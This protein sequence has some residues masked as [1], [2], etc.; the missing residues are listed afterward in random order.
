MPLNI[1]TKEYIMLDKYN[2]WTTEDFV[3]YIEKLENQINSKEQDQT[4]KI[5]WAGNL[6]QWTWF[7]KENKVIFNDLKVKS[8]GYDPQSIGKVNFEFFTTKLHPEDYERVMNNMRNHLKGKTGAYEVEYRIRHQDGHYLWYYDRGV[9]VKRENDGT[10]IVLEGIVFD[11]SESKEV[12][13]KLSFYAERD[14]LTQ[15]MNRRMFFQDINNSIKKYEN[16]QKEFSLIMVDLD[17]FKTINDTYGHLVGDET[18]VT[19]IKGIS[20]AKELDNNLY[21]YGGDEFFMLL[22]N[23]KLEDAIRFGKN[24]QNIIQNLQF[25]QNL[26]L[27]ASMGIVEYQDSESIDELIKRVDDLMYVAKQKGRNQFAF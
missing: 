25:P 11:I 27:T 15:V 4:V 7:Y 21:R 1:T 8:L 18:L 3:A 20:E 10:P 12:E 9:V 6:G 16:N 24:L 19:L 5:K 13:Q 14:I 17:H 22:P 26:Q 2:N 23:T